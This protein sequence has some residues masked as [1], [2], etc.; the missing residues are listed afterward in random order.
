MDFL[1][2]D[3]ELL[4]KVL[5]IPPSVSAKLH[6]YPCQVHT[7]SGH[8]HP[9][10]YI[11]ELRQFNTRWSVSSNIQREVKIEDVNIIFESPHRLP[12]EMATKLYLEG[13]SGMGYT[14]L[15][16]L[17]K[18][19]SSQ[20]YQTGNAVDFIDY[21]EGKG[22]GD[23]K[24]VVPHEGRHAPALKNGRKYAWCLYSEVSESENNSA[25]LSSSEIGQ[26]NLFEDK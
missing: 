11:V 7:K 26:G 21:P 20:T 1:E 23:V 17:F 5:T 15:K 25:G 19:G 9:C 14:I 18:D 24:D 6:Y 13:E 8:I 22:P 10:V 16:V 4:K 2:I 12:A 3:S